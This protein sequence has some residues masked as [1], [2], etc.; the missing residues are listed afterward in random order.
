MK[1]ASKSLDTF[2]DYIVKELKPSKFSKKLLKDQVSAQKSRLVTL[3]RILKF[4]ISG[5]RRDVHRALEPTVLLAMTPTYDKCASQSG[6]GMFERMKKIMAD[7][8]RGAKEDMFGMALQQVRAKMKVRLDSEILPR[9]KEEADKVFNTIDLD[10]RPLA[11][12]RE[13]VQKS[14]QYRE[15]KLTLLSL[16]V[17]ND[18]TLKPF[19]EARQSSGNHGKVKSEVDSNAQT[20]VNSE[21]D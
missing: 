21:S 7:G 8:V 12:G 14:K 16:L 19:L 3:E 2:F 4:Q 18:E 13:E 17:E 1:N 5:L 15:L 10:T 9:L 20:G 11:G 6:T